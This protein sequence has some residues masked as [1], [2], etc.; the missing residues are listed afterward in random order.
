VW[1]N[2][3]PVFQD[4]PWQSWA[5]AAHRPALAWR[6][7]PRIANNKTFPGVSNSAIF[8][9]RAVVKLTKIVTYQAESDLLAPLRPHYAPAPNRHRDRTFCVTV[10]QEV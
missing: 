6:S 8:N 5:T 3:C 7:S 9:E 2:T 1:T 10:C 4:R